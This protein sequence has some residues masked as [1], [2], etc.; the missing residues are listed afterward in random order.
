MWEGSCLY[1]RTHIECK[2]WVVV[3]P[4][5]LQRVTDCPAVS[6]A[7][8]LTVLRR[9]FEM[10]TDSASRSRNNRLRVDVTK[11]PSLGTSGRGVPNTHM[12]QHEM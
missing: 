9:S 11:Q 12:L 6:R 2:H 1:L 7:P 3:R 5:V 10:H 8:I 4:S